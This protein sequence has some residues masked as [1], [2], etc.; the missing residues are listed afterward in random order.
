MPGDTDA[1]HGVGRGSVG[2]K[3]AP[4]WQLPVQNSPPLCDP[5]GPKAWVKRITVPITEVDAVISVRSGGAHR[6][7]R[8]GRGGAAGTATCHCLCCTH[9]WP[10][11]TTT[12]LSQGLFCSEVEKNTLCTNIRK[13]PQHSCSKSRVGTN[14]Y[15]VFIYS[16]GDQTQVIRKIYGWNMVIFALFLSQ[17]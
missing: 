14:I 7:K 3:L 1:F 17:L 12:R 15:I 9:P 13:K 4:A 11:G 16:R 2:A 8:G 6:W 5:A 10:W